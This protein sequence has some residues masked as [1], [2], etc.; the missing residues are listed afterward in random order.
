MHGQTARDLQPIAGTEGGQAYPRLYRPQLAVSKFRGIDL[1]GRA[2]LIRIRNI[3]RRA[4]DK[5]RF[6]K[7][8][9]LLP[10]RQQYWVVLS[11]QRGEEGA[12]NGGVADDRK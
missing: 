2:Q 11:L 3:V 10:L 12:L 1:M 9:I 7:R 5:C 6:P 4:I 8:E